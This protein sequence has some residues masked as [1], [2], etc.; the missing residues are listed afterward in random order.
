MTNESDKLWALHRTVRDGLRA[1][2]FCKPC[3]ERAA[4]A[5]TDLAE[6]KPPREVKLCDPCK[7]IHERRQAA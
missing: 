1:R 7:R 3:A 2:G 5:A 6:S 4:F